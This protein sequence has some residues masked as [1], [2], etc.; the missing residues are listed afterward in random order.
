MAD[1]TTSPGSEK[2]TQQYIWEGETTQPQAKKTAKARA[3]YKLRQRNKDEYIVRFTLPGSV[4]WI[5]GRV[6]RLD[7]SW[8]R[9]WAGNTRST[10]ASIGAARTGTPPRSRRISI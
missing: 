5:A 8:G 4:E 10:P 3:Q 6:F 7:A 2:L 1:E 9:K